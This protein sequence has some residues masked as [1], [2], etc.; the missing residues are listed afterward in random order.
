ME[1]TSNVNEQKESTNK[2]RGLIFFLIGLVA[3]LAVLSGY[4]YVKMNGLK[5]EAEKLKTQQEQSNRDIDEYRAQL[6][7]LT[8]KYDSLMQAHEGLRSE[9]TQERDKVV[10]LMRDYE[11]LKATGGSTESTGGKNLRARL[12]ELQQAYDENEAIILDLKAKNQ[13]LT[14]ENFKAS[15]KVE[16][17]NAQNSKL[18]DE[19]GKLTK[20]V[21]VAKR[22]KTYEVYADAVRLNSD[23]TKE[24]PTTKASK[25]DRIRVCFTVLDNQIADK[26]EKILYAVIKDPD[27]KTFSNGDRS[28]IS[29]LN[30]TEVS[31]SVKKEIFY[32]NKVMQLCMNWDVV[33]EEKLTPGEYQ[34]EIYAEGVQIGT[35]T[36]EL[37]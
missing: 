19:N 1:T 25:A 13:E 36:F 18:T 33:S 3:A 15:K 22:L 21:D 34:V 23:K 17:L 8:A 37:K 32:D 16:E 11:R 4:L 2:G 5:A 30:G 26:Q 29:L 28:S 9:L 35:S 12:E 7:D 27:G 24:K 10:A 20:T 31:Y 6:Q 14:D